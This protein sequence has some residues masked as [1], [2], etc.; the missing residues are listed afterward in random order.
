MGCDVV[1]KVYGF[2]TK[3]CCVSCHEDYEEFGYDLCELTLPDE[4]VIECCCV[5]K[6]YVDSLK[7]A[8]ELKT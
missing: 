6:S 3:N 7:K 1:A 8:A 5:A 4:I 2:D